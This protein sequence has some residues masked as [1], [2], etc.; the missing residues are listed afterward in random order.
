MSVVATAQWNDDICVGYRLC[1]S[2]ILTIPVAPLVSFCTVNIYRNYILLRLELKQL[3]SM[4]AP[5]T[6]MQHTH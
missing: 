6:Y 1:Q 2:Y 5:S 4:G 3:N